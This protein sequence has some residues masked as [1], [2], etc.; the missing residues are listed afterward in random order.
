VE[1][2]LPGQNVGNDF[3]DQTPEFAQQ[4]TGIADNSSRITFNQK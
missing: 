4:A 1:D 3:V 2:H